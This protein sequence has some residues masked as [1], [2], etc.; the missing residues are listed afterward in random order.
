MNIAGNAEAN[1]AATVDA[2]IATALVRITPI[3][4][5]QKIIKERKSTMRTKYELS[6]HEIAQAITDSEYLGLCRH[7][8]SVAECVEPDARNYK[9]GACGMLEVFG[10]EELL[11]M[12]EIEVTDEPTDKP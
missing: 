11:L 9:C 10:L 3:M 7:C 5:A 1:C 4:M 12:G 8:G 2:I 6:S